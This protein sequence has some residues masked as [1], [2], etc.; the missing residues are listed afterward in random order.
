[1][2]N[3]LKCNDVQ[4]YLNRYQDNELEPQLRLD[5]ESHLQSCQQ[6]SAQ[7]LQLEEVTASLLQLPQQEPAMNFTARVMAD[8]NK[9]KS[10]QWFAFPSLLYSLVFIIFC[11][12]G[13]MLN[14]YLKPQA[15]P[16]IPTEIMMA[17][18]N[19]PMVSTIAGY[20]DILTQSRDLNL[21]GI[22]DKTLEM[23]YNRTGSNGNNGNNGE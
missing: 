7:L 11:L 4:R 18:I 5:V 17:S 21:M 13:F 20:S 9:K 1:M 14:P 19:T 23:V 6:C 8:V 16:V 22:Q 3:I 15:A 2:T 12:L 10:S